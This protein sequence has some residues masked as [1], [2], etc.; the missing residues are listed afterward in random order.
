[1]KK[2]FTSLTCGACLALAAPAL[3]ATKAETL[4]KKVD[5]LERELAHFKKEMH[6]EK[7]LAKKEKAHESVMEHDLGSTVLT[8]SYFIYRSAD[9]A[10]DLIATLPTMNLDLRILQ[11]KKKWYQDLGNRYPSADRPRIQLSGALEGLITSSRDFSDNNRSDINVGKAEIDVLVDASPWASAFFSLN[12]D[13]AALPSGQRIANSR[14]YLKRGFLTVG[15]LV[16]FPVYGSVGQ[17][18]V[19]FIR[20]ATGAVVLDP[21]TQL[22]G[23]TNSRALVVGY[24][25]YGVYAQAYGFRSDAATVD[26]QGEINNWGLNAGYKFAEGDWKGEFGAGYIDNIANAAAFQSSNNFGAT[27]SGTNVEILQK[28]V[29]AL[30]LHGMVRYDKFR[31]IAEYVGALE[32]FDPTDLAYNGTGAR[33]TALHTEVNYD[34]DVMG[35]TV[36]VGLGYGHTWQAL[37]LNLPQ[38]R[39]WILSRTS[40]FKNTVQALELQYDKNYSFNDTYVSNS[41]SGTVTNNAPGVRSDGYTVLFNFGV[42]F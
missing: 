3:A 13:S 10:S 33:P 29:S 42:Y 27:V 9:D 11:D 4:E 15:N 34:F 17:M 39:Y 1:M 23:R 25:D 24:N 2:I 21:V 19:P 6:E 20:N 32:G 22:L 31:V 26:N 18:Y 41:G 38:E 8:S 40:L 16:E 37:P 30:N 12:Y 35:K 14:I 28:S 7:M 36:A 5:R